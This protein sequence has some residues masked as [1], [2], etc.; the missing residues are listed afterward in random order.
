[1]RSGYSPLQK[2]LHWL[3]VL[4]VVAQWWTSAAIYRTHAHDPFGVG[5]DP[6]DLIEHKLHI[7]GGLLIL[8]LTILRLAVRWRTGVPALPAGLSLASG[9]LAHW[10]HAGLYL[11]L[12]GL[13]ATGVVTS[14]FWFGMGKVHELLVKGLYGLVFL[15]VAATIWHEFVDRIAILHRMAPRAFTRSDP[16]K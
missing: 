11:V 13:T 12:F 5:P 4:L 1:M 10:G 7:Y 3:T 6:I 2:S 15:H 8:G 16:V 14:Y 9:R